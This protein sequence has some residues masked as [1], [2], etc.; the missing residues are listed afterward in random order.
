MHADALC[1][2][3]SMPLSAHCA[4]SLHRHAALAARRL[5][6]IEWFHD[7]VR[8]EQ[9]LFDGAPQVV[10]GTITVDGSRPGLGIELKRADA[11]RFRP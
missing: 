7:H 4:P 1:D 10:N 5:W 11:E 2:A 6:N 8:I 9:L 3:Y